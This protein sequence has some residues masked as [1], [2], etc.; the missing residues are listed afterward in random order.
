VVPPPDPLPA[1]STVSPASITF[2]NTLV[3]TSAPAWT[4]TYQNNGS[5]ALAISGISSSGDYSQS[6][7]CGSSLAIAGVCSIN[8][9]F[10]PSSSGARNGSLQIAGDSPQNV[11]LSGSGVTLHNV[12]LNWDASA[13][14]VV[15]YFVYTGS[16]SG[17]P[18][19]LQNAA[20]S[21]SL[22]YQLNLQGGQTWYLI[23]TAVDANQIES[24]PSNEVP[25][26]VPP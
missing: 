14:L 16:V 19:I 20:P 17:G 10:T 15:G 8:V 6:N 26:V 21:P 4:I 24:F 7:N 1:A 18:Y 2:A 3:G 11:P 23:V 25:A 9:V 13:S 12:E 22:N 5:A